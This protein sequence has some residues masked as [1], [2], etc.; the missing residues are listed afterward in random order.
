MVNT[1]GQIVV[2]WIRELASHWELQ[3]DKQEIHMSFPDKK[4]RGRRSSV[5]VDADVCSC[6]ACGTVVLASVGC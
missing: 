3:P 1:Q 5:S 6:P 4:V 2:A